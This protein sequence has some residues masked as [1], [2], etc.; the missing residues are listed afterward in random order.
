MPSPGCIAYGSVGE[1]STDASIRSAGGEYLFDWR[2]A[3]RRVD[4]HAFAIPPGALLSSMVAAPAVE[5]PQR[6][7]WSKVETSGTDNGAS[8]SAK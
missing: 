8:A 5:P 1:R 6:V 2:C 4:F 3:E 7:Y